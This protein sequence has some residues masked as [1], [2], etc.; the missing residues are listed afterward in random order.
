ML[1]IRDQIR[2]TIAA[3]Q[4]LYATSIGFGTRKTVDA[5]RGSAVLQNEVNSLEEE[6]RLLGLEALEQRNKNASVE[7]RLVMANDTYAKRCLEEKQ[8]LHHQKRSLESFL[9]EQG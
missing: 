5:E 1:R 3:Y 2:M 4:T 9:E 8:L 6:V 7:R